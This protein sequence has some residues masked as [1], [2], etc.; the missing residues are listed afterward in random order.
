MI[1]LLHEFITRAAEQH[2]DG[3]AVVV[4]DNRLTY[5]QLEEQVAVTAAGLVGAGLQRHD[6]VSI[7]LT[8]Q[9]ECVTGMFGAARAG[10]I[11]IPV[12]P[13]LKAQQVAHILKDSGSRVLITTADRY[14]SLGQVL[15]EC[16][17]LRL[18]VLNDGKGD[19]AP[20]HD[21]CRVLDWNGLIG[22]A[23]GSPHRMISSDAVAILYTSGSTGNPKG[24]VLSHRNM[25]AGGEIVSSYIE[26]RPSDRILAVLPFGFDAGFSQLSTAF[27]TGATVVLHDYFMARDVLKIVASEKITGITGVPPLWIQI[28]E[29]DWTEKESSTVRYFANTGGK[30]PRSLL[31]RLRE[32]FPSAKPYLMYGLTEAFRST[33]LPPEEVDRRPDSI[34]KAIPDNE[35]LVVREDG[36]LCDPHEP[37]EL[38]HR[39]SL[40]SMGYWNNPEKT[41]E[42]FKPLMGVSPNRSHTE[43]AVWSGDI[44]KKD[45]DGFL[46]FVGRKDDMIKTSGYRVSPTEVEE[47]A[48]ASGLVAEAAAIGV[49]DDRLGQ[50]IVLVVA[51]TKSGKQDTDAL[52]QHMKKDMPAFMVPSAIEWRAGLPRNPNGKINRKLI[53]QEMVF[54]PADRKAL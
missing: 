6:R 16:P 45:E 40:V 43:T 19:E 11:F 39:G 38:V 33:Y 50:R 36:S 44:A 13:V 3:E 20:P 17:D 4:K 42:R 21:A 18:V 34:G 10:G 51:P 14:A 2:A 24:V 41:A 5:E 15:R 46:Y 8:K 7:Y 1:N 52:L 53:A 22:S 35:I 48:Y 27:C 37:G 30:M 9:L 31:A 25:V 23:T 32:C 12:N 47:M 29:Q 49:E 26:N 28:A 54:E